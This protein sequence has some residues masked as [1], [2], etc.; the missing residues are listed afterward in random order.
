MLL[1]ELGIA[2]GAGRDHHQV[3]A[4]LEDRLA[5]VAHRLLARRLDHDVG[6]ELQQRLEGFDHRHL[7]ADL[8]L[9]FLGAPGPHQDTDDVDGRLL[10][11]E[12]VEQGL[13]DRAVADQRDLEP[14]LLG[15]VIPPRE[16]AQSARL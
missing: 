7:A 8:L 4:L 16:D 2:V 6:L 9:R 13:A 10:D 11:G 1:P 12:D 15:H 3:D 14:L 5:P